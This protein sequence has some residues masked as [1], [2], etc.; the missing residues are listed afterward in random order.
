MG[1]KSIGMKMISKEYNIILD[2][3][4]TVD[5][6]TTKIA[7]YSVARR[8]MLLKN[9]NYSEP[10]SDGKWRLVRKTSLSDKVFRTK[11][12]EGDFKR[13]DAVY[14]LLDPYIQKRQ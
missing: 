12:I 2:V 11:S 4:E 8:S 7:R 9:R 14:R 13:D 10:S 3:L 1:R 6:T 5:D